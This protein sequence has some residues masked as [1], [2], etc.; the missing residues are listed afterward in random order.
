MPRYAAIMIAFLRSY[1]GKN[2]F[3]IC[4][5]FRPPINIF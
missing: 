3:A 4:K 5:A 1:K 2:K